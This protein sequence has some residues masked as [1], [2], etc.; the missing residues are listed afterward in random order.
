MIETL[1]IAG[2]LFSVGI[3]VILIDKALKKTFIPNSTTS[4]AIY[5]IWDFF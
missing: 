3:I 4:A 5:S 1:A 2:G